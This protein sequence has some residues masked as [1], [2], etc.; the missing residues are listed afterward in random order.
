MADRDRLHVE[1]STVRTTTDR[2]SVIARA[3]ALLRDLPAA[4]HEARPAQRN[5]L[6]RLIFQSVEIEDDRVA[7]VVP[8][9]DFA[10]FFALAENNETGWSVLTTPERQVLSLA[11]GSDGDRL[12]EID[13]VELPLVPFLFP[14]RLLCSRRRGEAGR[15]AVAVKGPRIPREQWPEVAARARREG[16]R[17]VARDF[18]VSHETV[19]SVVLA[20]GTEIGVL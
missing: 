5:A 1:L 9:R 2:S 7:A 8:Q 15:Y 18:G 4:W 6:A 13:V 20:I 16:L 19:R 3:A 17:A 14:D 11:G 10:P 12:R